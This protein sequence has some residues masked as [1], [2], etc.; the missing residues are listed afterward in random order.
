MQMS[1]ITEIKKNSRF[2]RKNREKT[3]K[4]QHFHDF[5]AKTV[6]REPQKYK[7]ICIHSH[8]N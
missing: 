5:L 8:F 7:N 6:K 3:I 1:K 2:S 4:L